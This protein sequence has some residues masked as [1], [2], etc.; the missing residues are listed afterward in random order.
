MSGLEA[1]GIA[2]GLIQIAD[3]GAN[4]SIRLFTFYRQMKT[5]NKSVQNLSCDVALTSTIMRQLAENLRRDEQEEEKARVCSREAFQTAEEILGQCRGVF[6]EIERTIERS[7]SE[8]GKRCWRDF[9]GK[10]KNVLLLEPDFNVLMGNLERLK[11]S[12]LLLLN[13][14][15][16]GGQVRG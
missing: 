10:A 1:I 7:E 14:I 2:G 3:L 9:I 12:M 8:S 5:V 6:G 11:S 13:V 15:M 16:Y 4:L